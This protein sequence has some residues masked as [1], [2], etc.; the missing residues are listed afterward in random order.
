MDGKA[1]QRKK[2][3]ALLTSRGYPPVLLWVERGSA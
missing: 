2:H 3:D 1:L